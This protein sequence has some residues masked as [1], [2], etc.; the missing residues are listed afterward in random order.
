MMTDFV[1]SQKKSWTERDS[2]LRQKKFEPAAKCIGILSGY[3]APTTRPY[4]RNVITKAQAICGPSDL[5]KKSLGVQP[6]QSFQKFQ[7]AGHLRYTDP[8][9][10]HT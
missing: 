7:A 4:Y 10:D 5:M 2:N 1:D 9:T 8:V 3:R 6:L